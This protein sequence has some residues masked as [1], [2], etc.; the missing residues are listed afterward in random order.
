VIA[1]QIG[2]K[3]GMKKGCPRKDRNYRA[4]TMKRQRA[5]SGTATAT[6]TVYKNRDKDRDKN[7]DKCKDKNCE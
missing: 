4:G 6:G 1:K 3:R 5:E 7:E 2:Q